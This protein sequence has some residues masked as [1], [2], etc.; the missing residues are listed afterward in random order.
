M[1]LLVLI[2]KHPVKVH[3]WGGIS[4]KGRTPIVIFE[5]I[6]NAEGFEK[7]HREGLLPF[8]RD[9]YPAGHRLMQDNDPKHT[10]KR[11]VKFLQEEGVNW[12]ETPPDSPD[13]NPV[14]NPWHELKEFFWE[15][16]GVAKCRKY[17]K[18]L[19]QV[20]PRVIELNGVPTGY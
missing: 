7:I 8:L 19:R 6:M 1:Y 15:T 10:S 18:H 13:C 3:V 12:W 5:G 9:T 11:V 16:V 4:W 20:I 14:E 2:A 17:I